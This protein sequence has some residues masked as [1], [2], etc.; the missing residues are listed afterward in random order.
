MIDKVYIIN[1]E[2]C[3]EKKNNMEKQVSKLNLNYKF[4]KAI[5]GTND[6][7]LSKY[8]YKIPN[9]T[10]P[11]SGK[12]MTR[13]EIGCALSHYN[14][15]L[16]INK[17]IKNGEL[18]ENCKVLILEDDVIFLDNFIEDYEKYTKGL[19]YDMLYLHRKALNEENETPL[20]EFN[21]IYNIR[22][23]YWL[24][25]Y[26]LTYEGVKKLINANYLENLIPAD[27]FV[28]IMY[29]TN[30]MGFEKYYKQYPKL[31]C[32]A[33][34][35]SLLKLNGNAFEESETFHSYPINDKFIFDNNK[36]F[37]LIYIGKTEGSNYERF[38]NYCLIYNVPLIGIE[39]N[40]TQSN[41]LFKELNNWDKEKRLNSFITVIVD[42]KN[43][44]GNMLIIASP[45]EIINK[46]KDLNTSKILVQNEYERSDQMILF[47]G[48][49]SKIYNYLNNNL[50][51]K[52]KNIEWRIDD[53]SIKMLFKI[54]NKDIQEDRKYE[55]FQELNENHHITVSETDNRI[56]N[57]KM[58]TQPCIVYCNKYN[59]IILNNMENYT[60]NNWNG[61][62]GYKIPN[63]IENKP[64]IYIA[65][66]LEF[67]KNILKIL[68]KFN[69]SKELLNINI[70]TK[71]EDSFYHNSIINF[72]KSDCEYYFLIDKCSV[73]V[74]P[75]II[76]ELLALR[77]DV[78]APLIRKGNEAWTNYWG[79]LDN[80]GYYK[81]SFDYFDIIE[82]KKKG[83]WN[84]PYITGVYLIK[85]SIIEKNPRIYIDNSNIDI[86]MRIC[87]N[88]RDNNVFMYV[89]NINNYGYWEEIEEPIDFQNELIINTGELTMYDIF[90]RKEEWEKKY[91]HPDFN[92]NVENNKF[93]EICGD[94]FNFKLFT[95]DFCD[96]MIETM[97]KYGKWSH[98][99][100]EHKDERLG[101]NYYENVPT[102]DIQLFQINMDKQW[103]FLVNNYIAPIVKHLF[104]S[105][106][107]K[108]VHM[109][110]VVKYHWNHQAELEPHHDASN[111]TLNIALNQGGVDYEGGGCRF[112]RQKYSMIN[113]EVGTCTLHPGRLTHYHEGLKTTKGIR[114]IL[115][116][117]VE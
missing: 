2:R 71:I 44:L 31:E 70:N 15:W 100:D 51:K 64:K 17:S 80:R 67:N 5:D 18:S 41:L 101:K 92:K 25:A 69:Y 55:I 106:V 8:N 84:V 4:F 1:L 75:N 87:Y 103:G 24:C 57:V 111:Y 113:Q 73:L 49:T 105:Y 48:W 28:P 34:K 112:I 46:Y 52:E 20:K 39:N 85:R 58:N 114:Y 7:D 47:C 65:V 10:D 33:I 38:K 13:G 78:V 6:E 36:E 43:N 9:W 81:R 91:L 90:T 77:K 35:P 96:E 104:C 40:D 83:C 45:Q 102:Q 26:V 76:N 12:P 117:F 86:D 107:T 19:K 30:V 61:Y 32:Y 29:G 59:R 82:N 74:N 93:T 116:T 3:K 88:L 79:A 68:D 22:K 97:E 23:N 54:I 66:N 53:Y 108:H 16:D 11:N 72:I 50:E 27:E 110:F 21:H 115:V 94:V 14:V 37:K 109:A 95:K 98:G 60:G 63:E 99:K 56:T 62:Y 89:S 42:K